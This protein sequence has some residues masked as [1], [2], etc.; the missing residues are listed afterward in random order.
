MKRCPGNQSQP[1]KKR[2]HLPDLQQPRKLPGPKEQRGVQLRQ[3]KQLVQGRKVSS[4]S[5]YG[6][7]A[8]Y[9]VVR[10]VEFITREQICKMNL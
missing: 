8:F 9:S 5:A 10:M 6:A 1:R 2:L 3:K 4:K 7:M